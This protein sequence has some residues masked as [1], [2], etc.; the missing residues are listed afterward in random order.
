MWPIYKEYDLIRYKGENKVTWIWV[1]RHKK[2]DLYEKYD[3][4]IKIRKM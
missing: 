3:L 1:L 2:C 4:G